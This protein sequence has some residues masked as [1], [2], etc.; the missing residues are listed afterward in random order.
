MYFKAVIT[1]LQNEDDVK[2]VVAN[3][4]NDIVLDESKDV[5][6]EVLNKLKNLHYK[7]FNSTLTENIFMY[8][9]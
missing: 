9:T 4:F 6:L 1:L 5:L 3:N 7:R 2:V 8:I